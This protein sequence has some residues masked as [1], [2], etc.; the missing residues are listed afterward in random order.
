MGVAS[1][2][3]ILLGL[4][5]GL[6][7]SGGCSRGRLGGWLVL[8]FPACVVGAGVVGCLVFG[9]E[10]TPAVVVGRCGCCGRGGLLVVGVPVRAC[11]RV[12]V[13]CCRGS[14]VVRPGCLACGSA[15]LLWGGVVGVGGLVVNCIVDASIITVLFL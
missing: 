1:R 15:S 9:V 2:P 8:W 4:L 5:M 11:V 14:G 10:D 13:A 12:G 3:L 7:R 6:G